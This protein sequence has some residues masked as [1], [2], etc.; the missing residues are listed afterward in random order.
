MIDCQECECLFSCYISILDSRTSLGGDLVDHPEEELFAQ[1]DLGGGAQGF[2]LVTVH[3]TVRDDDAGWILWF[4]VHMDMR[5][6]IKSDK[7]QGKFQD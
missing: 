7:T 1:G 4:I 6:G 2:A 5:I 3:A